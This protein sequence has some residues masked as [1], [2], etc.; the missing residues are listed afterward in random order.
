MQHFAIMLEDLMQ[1]HKARVMIDQ[2][3]V[4]FVYHDGTVFALADKCPHMG[5]SLFKGTV[6][7]G[8]V[9]CRAHRAKIDIKTGAIEEKAR[10]MFL[11]LPT[12]KAKTYPVV[13]K[14]GKVFVE[15]G[16]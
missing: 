12:R 2:T 1:Q 5:A 13:I 8:I 15:V 11:R 3:A 14:D 9:T 6:E 10:M 7:N 4:L 16:S